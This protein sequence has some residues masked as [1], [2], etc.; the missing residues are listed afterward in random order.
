MFSAK[1]AY[2]QALANPPSAIFD[3]N[4]VALI[5]P[6][7][8]PDAQQIIQNVNSRHN[9]TASRGH[10]SRASVS[11][12]NGHSRM[13]SSSLRAGHL[14]SL[15]GGIPEHGVSIPNGALLGYGREPSPT[16]PNIP[17]QPTL[18]SLILSSSSFG[19]DVIL[20]DPAILA[21]STEVPVGAGPRIGDPGKRMLGAA[22]GVRHPGLG[23]RMVGGGG[24][25]TLM[26]EVQKAMGGLVVS[27]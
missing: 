4:L 1:R 11:V 13:A 26:K 14:K 19:E 5:R 12:S 10:N 2:L 8:G 21:A 22:L 16:L 27:D 15:G 18:D 24:D 7:D 23:P 17:S 9:S 3:N 6:Y 25:Q 20:N